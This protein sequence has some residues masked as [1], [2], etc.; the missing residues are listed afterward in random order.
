M[1]YH[2]STSPESRNGSL[3]AH[4]G[5]IKTFSIAGSRGNPAWVLVPWIV[6]SG[7]RRAEPTPF[8]GYIPEHLAF[9]HCV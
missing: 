1:H 6:M 9:F 8:S 5:M 2:K 4:S 3:G 7:V